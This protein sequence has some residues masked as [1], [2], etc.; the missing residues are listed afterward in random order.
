MER[1]EFFVEMMDNLFDIG[2]SD[3]NENM[4]IEVFDTCKITDRNGLHINGCCREFGV[5]LKI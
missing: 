1:R 5:I 4:K 2:H 3:A